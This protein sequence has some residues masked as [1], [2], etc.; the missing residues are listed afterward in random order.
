MESSKAA[1]PEEQG[2]TPRPRSGTPAH[3][4]DQAGAGRRVLDHEVELHFHKVVPVIGRPEARR[5]KE[6]SATP[7]VPPPNHT[8]GTFAAPEPVM[9]P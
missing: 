6:A 3:H 1:R 7:F 8:L 9:M 5:I 4:I 2:M